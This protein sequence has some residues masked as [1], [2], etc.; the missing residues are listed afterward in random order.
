MGLVPRLG[1]EGLKFGVTGL[2]G[3]Y[4]I[5]EAFAFVNRRVPLF[6]WREFLT[7]KGGVWVWWSRGGS[8]P[9]YKG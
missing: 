5:L 7:R 2:P 8:S 6:L 3:F 4:L 1:I 9:G